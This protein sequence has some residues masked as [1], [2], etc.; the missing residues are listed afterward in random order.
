MLMQTIYLAGPDVFYPDT[1]RRKEK[2]LSLCTKYGF[3]GLYPGDNEIHPITAD[4]IRDANLEMI[5]KADYVIANVNCFRGFE[6]DSGT[7]FEIGFAIALGKKVVAYAEDLRPLKVKLCEYQKLSPDST[8][9]KDGLHI[10]DFNLPNN[11]MFGS[12]VIAESP[13]QAIQN[14]ING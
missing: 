8:Q 14:L 6:P 13:E 12:L 3:K 2:L 1:Q 5:K 9:D 10:E 7:V 4:N 11:L